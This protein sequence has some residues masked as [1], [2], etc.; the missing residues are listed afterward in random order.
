MARIIQ[1]MPYTIEEHNH[2]MS[3][4]VASRA[5]STKKC[6]F[7][8]H[9]GVSI[10]EASGFTP[11]FS[12]P[13]QLPDLDQLDNTHRKWRSKVIREAKK[14][15]IRFTHGIAAK[16]INCYL[17]VRFV[18]AG[19]HDDMRVRALHPPIDA[20]LLKELARLNFGGKA[21]TWRHYH[22]AGWSNFKSKTY[23]RVINHIR[24]SLDG[25]PLWKIE[26]H[27]KGHQ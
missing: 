25:K 9:L 20:V 12:R 14:R 19:A 6:R 2:R 17:K 27:W 7:K 1:A 24:K 21:K 10:L 15:G 23:Q 22:Q 4:W 3:A 18:C 8:V 16:L 11:D 13:K 26:E 5:A